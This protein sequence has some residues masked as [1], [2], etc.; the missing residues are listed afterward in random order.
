MRDG[1]LVEIKVPG[2]KA[3]ATRTVPDRVSQ[4]PVGLEA[5]GGL[6]Q[7]EVGRARFRIVLVKSPSDT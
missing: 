5:G 6:R 1:H 2:L 7:N 4:Q 3:A